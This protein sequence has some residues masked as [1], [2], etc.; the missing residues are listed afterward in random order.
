MGG[1]DTDTV[2]CTSA[3]EQR[4]FDAFLGY[5][6]G[7]EDYYD[8]TVSKNCGVMTRDLWFASSPTNGRSVAT[9]PPHTHTHTVAPVAFMKCFQHLPHKLNLFMLAHT[10]GA[11]SISM[12]LV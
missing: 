12:H 7:G 5:F 2:L 4:G 9:P 1:T 6:V 10:D 8:H 3:E 11:S